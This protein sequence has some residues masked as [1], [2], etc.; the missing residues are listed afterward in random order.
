LDELN[1]FEARLPEI[2]IKKTDGKYAL[3]MGKEVPDE[4]QKAWKD[5]EKYIEQFVAADI[6]LITCPIW[7]F[8]IPY[9]LKHYIDLIFQPGYLFSYSEKGPE[10]LLKNKKMIVCTSRGGDY[11]ESS[12]F[13]PY[14]FQEPYLR[15]AFG[16]VGIN[17][18]TFFNAQPM[19]AMGP[20]VAQ[21]K[22]AEVIDNIRTFVRACS[23]AKKTD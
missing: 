5:V 8:S 9:V 10:G 21:Q 23:C 13:H 11:S 12:P 2:G 3:L 20:D 7:N 18:I 4:C 19:D 17:E 22:I 1:L 14:D 16:F 15:A 6:Y